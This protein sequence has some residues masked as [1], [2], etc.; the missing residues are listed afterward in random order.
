MNNKQKLL[1]KRAAAKV[2]RGK[3]NES[4]STSKSNVMSATPSQKEYNSKGVTPVSSAK[5]PTQFKTGKQVPET[6]GQTK[7]SPYNHSK[8]TSNTTS[9]SNSN[10]GSHQIASNGASVKQMKPKSNI[11]KQTL[12]NPYPHE[13]QKVISPFQASR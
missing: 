8:L 10:P 12:K 4:Q 13:E 6:H 1:A 9:P 5:T 3:I 11:Q 2:V 7:P